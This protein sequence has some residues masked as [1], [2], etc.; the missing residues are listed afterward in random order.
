MLHSPWWPP[1]QCA[2]PECRSLRGLLAG[3]GLKPQLEQAWA[4][5]ASPLMYLIPKG[6]CGN[7]GVGVGAQPS[8]S[9]PE[10]ST[11]TPSSTLAV[12]RPILCHPG[13]SDL[14]ILVGLHI[15][16]PN[17]ADQGGIVRVLPI[18]LVIDLQGLFRLVGKVTRSLSLL[19]NWR[20]KTGLGVGALFGK[21]V[22]LLTHF[23]NVH[24]SITKKQAGVGARQMFTELPAGITKSLSQACASL[25]VLNPVSFSLLL[26]L[27]HVHSS[28]NSYCE[29]TC[30]RGPVLATSV[31]FSL[32]FKSF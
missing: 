1:H 5:V 12:G 16:L 27:A 23:L 13:Q 31:R 28:A 8:S 24:E 3:T 26:I 30:V 2:P 22:G 21:A 20:S 18:G 7:R 4:V 25:V 10:P 11:R 19:S 32:F 14:G 6:H 9:N 29:S 17:P 15:R